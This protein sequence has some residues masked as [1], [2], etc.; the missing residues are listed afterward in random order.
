MGTEGILIASGFTPFVSLIASGFTP[1]VSSKATEFGSCTLWHVLKFYFILLHDS[2]RDFILAQS[3]IVKNCHPQYVLYV[4][5]TRWNLA[6]YLN[7]F[8]CNLALPAA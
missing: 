2:D 1:C 6:N 8:A 5:F 7:R 4:T 3:S